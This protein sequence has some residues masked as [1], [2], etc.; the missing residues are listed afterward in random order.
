MRLVLVCALGGGAGS[1]AREK[2][3]SLH[4]GWKDRRAARRVRVY[5]RMRAHTLLHWYRSTGV[6]L[7][8]IQPTLGGQSPEG[9]S[10]LAARSIP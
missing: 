6:F 8:P 5:V 10:G 3:L 1:G 2:L 4:L 7:N 9:K